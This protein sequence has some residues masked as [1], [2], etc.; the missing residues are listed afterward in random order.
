MIVHPNKEFQRPLIKCLQL[1]A[2]CI[3]SVVTGLDVEATKR[4]A[5]LTKEPTVLKVLL[6]TWGTGK[7]AA[8]YAHV[9]SLPTEQT[10]DVNES[11]DGRTAH[12]GAAELGRQELEQ[13]CARIVNDTLALMEFQNRSGELELRPRE[14]ISGVMAATDLSQIIMAKKYISPAVDVGEG[15]TADSFRALIVGNAGGL[16]DEMFAHLL[17]LLVQLSAVAGSFEITY[18][19]PDGRSLA[20][21]RSLVNGCP[22]ELVR[23]IDKLHFVRATFDEFLNADTNNAEPFDYVDIGEP[24]SNFAADGK[25]LKAT[26]NVDTLRLLSTKLRKRRA[27]VRVWSFAASPVADLMF[28]ARHAYRKL[29]TVPRT[30]ANNSQ[31]IV[32]IPVNPAAEEALAKILR[33]RYGLGAGQSDVVNESPEDNEGFRTGNEEAEW[34]DPTA[35]PPASA[36]HLPR[37]EQIWAKQVLATVAPAGD[38]LMTVTDIDAVLSQARFK[39][40]QLLGDVQRYEPGAMSDGLRDLSDVKVIL[41]GMSQWE[42]A[43]LADSLAP[44]PVLVHQVLAV[45]RDESD[46][47]AAIF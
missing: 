36:Q 8:S 7:P 29:P 23:G 14:P 18:V 43:T 32:G 46:F 31:Q 6:E 12:V 2:C 28:R 9:M 15:Q 37:E 41:E 3:S 38:A 35:P 10:S 44:V 20:A 13:R 26:V 21:A 42:V 22:D 30:I 16:D 45:W 25:D 5:L 11:A 19:H 17:S 47:V 4:V 33:T 34:L 39:T 24:L 40:A 1:D 27:C